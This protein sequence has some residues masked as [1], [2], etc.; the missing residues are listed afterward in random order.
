MIRVFIFI[1]VLCLGWNTIAQPVIEWKKCYGGSA[2]EVSSSIQQTLDGGYIVA[3]RTASNDSDVVGNHGNFDY[4]I[5]RL[6]ASGELCWQKCLGGSSFDVGYSVWQTTDGKYIV[7]GLAASSDGDVT[8]NH[9]L[10]DY[11]I[12]RLDTE[13]NILWKKCLGGSGTDEANAIQQTSDGGYIVAGSTDSHDGDVTGL[14]GYSDDYWVVKLDSTG[15][16]Q[17]QKCLGGSN[18]DAG[19]DISQTVDGGYIVAGFSQSNDGDVSGNHGGDSDCWIVKLDAAGTI[20]WQKCFGGSWV[21]YAYSIRQTSDKGYIIAGFTSSNDGDVSGL[22]WLGGAWI[23]YDYWI[24]KID[25]SGTIQWQR[26]LGGFGT[27]DATCVRQ[28][29][30]GGFIVSGFTESDDGD[31]TGYHPGGP[32]CSFCWDYWIVKLNS[33]GQIEWQKC[34]GGNDWDQAYSISE[35]S[36][37][38]YIV[39]GQ[40][41]SNDG[42]IT[43][44]H[45][46]ADQWVIKFS[47]TVSIPEKRENRSLAIRPNPA[48]DYIILETDKDTRNG[49][50]SVIDLLGRRLLTQQ[51]ADNQQ[52]QMDIHSILPGIYSVLVEFHDT[53]RTTGLFVKINN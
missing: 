19:K 8:G 9:G 49:T 23:P 5:T 2:G 4:W 26:C 37:G 46:T 36:D 3:G 21:E 13:G 16:I 11:W 6:N 30:D 10:F 31:V 47:G 29:S 15:V 33:T 53:Q 38:G 27:D 34:L 50:I 20:E 41:E 1:S 40:T 22:H 42:D 25:S 14:H 39:A 32:N 7:A 44:N 12:I 51:G 45:G 48:S 43:G 24:V 28:T 52:I 18:Q 35:T 17:W